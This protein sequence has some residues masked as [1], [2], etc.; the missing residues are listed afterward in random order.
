MGL[1]G[2]CATLPMLLFYYSG[3]AKGANET[4]S[5]YEISLPD[6][7]DHASDGFP[8]GATNNLIRNG[9]SKAMHNAKQRIKNSSP[10]KSKAPR[11]HMQP[12]SKQFTDTHGKH[13]TKR[14]EVERSEETGANRTRMQELDKYF[15]NPETVKRTPAEENGFTKESFL[16][17]ISLD[18]LNSR[19]PDAE[20]ALQN[21]ESEL[22]TTQNLDQD[23][24][25]HFLDWS[26]KGL[27]NEEPTE[28]EVKLD[29]N[30]EKYG[31][32]SLEGRKI[33]NAASLLESSLESQGTG[34][35]DSVK[36]PGE[37]VGNRARA[38]QYFLPT[39][40][41]MKFKQRSRYRYV[42]SLIKPQ[43]A[44]ISADLIG[45]ESQRN[46]VKSVNLKTLKN[47]YKS[48]ELVKSAK[49]LNKAQV[50]ENVSERKFSTDP[51]A[52]DGNKDS[53]EQNDE[54]QYNAND[55]F[56]LGTPDHST[57]LEDVF[58][59]H[60]HSMHLFPGSGDEKYVPPGKYKVRAT[61]RPTLP[62]Q[63]SA[64]KEATAN[65]S[66]ISKVAF[67]KLQESGFQEEFIHSGEELD[68][69]ESNV[70]LN[71]KLNGGLPLI[72]HTDKKLREKPPGSL[73]L[74]KDKAVS[75]IEEESNYSYNQRNEDFVG[76]GGSAQA[77]RVRPSPYFR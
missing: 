53:T 14:T 51:Q 43:L 32:S 56:M 4:L 64:A 72:S 76:S 37:K 69:N 6:T 17:A 73:Q 19:Q 67:G 65:Q 3:D 15:V 12:K 23:V 18:G 59:A 74:L 44:G 68:S 31:E 11:E 50:G 46:P 13:A 2:S 36:Y 9:S 35:T 25:A 47:D 33:V 70:D 34:L 27:G 5:T 40:S 77:H 28:D 60:P 16:S 26:R 8:S 52:K 54:P 45:L 30:F 21:E 20:M 63:M 71:L 29:G 55:M 10:N 24:S 57:F 48:H 39:Q 7:K 61:A 1:L 75:H 49:Q 66:K 41:P 58:L 62:R 42:N 22:R 38:F